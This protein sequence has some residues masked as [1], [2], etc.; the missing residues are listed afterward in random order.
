[1]N[2]P[3]SPH[4]PDQELPKAY[5]PKAVEKEWYQ[6]WMKRGYF[7]ASSHSKKKPYTIVIPPPNITGI[8]HMGHALN[9]T[10]QDILI[11]YKR[12][13]GYEALWMPGTD[14]AG[15]ATQNVVEKSLKEEGLTRHALGR[16]KFLERVWKWRE[17][18]GNTIIRQLQ[19]LGASCDWE[20]TRF[21]MDEGLSR[22]VREVFVRLHEKGLIYRGRYIINW[23]P[24]CQTAL[25]DEEVQ[26]KDVTGHLY[27]LKYTIEGTDQ[28]LTIATT[29]PETMLGDTAVGFHP[30]DERYRHLIGKTVLLPLLNRKL[31]VI[32]DADIDPQFGTGA[33]KI[34]PAHDPVDFR[35]AQ[36]HHL[37]MIN[38][39]NPDGTLNDAAGPYKGL[40]RFEARRKIIAELEDRRILLETKEHVHAVGHCYRCQT[41]VEPTLSLQWFVH[42]K[43]LARP[44]IAAVKEGKTVFTPARWTKVYLDW[45]TNIKDWCIS[46]QIWWGHRIPVWYCPKCRADEAKIISSKNFTP[47]NKIYTET[48]MMVSRDAPKKCAACGHPDLIQDADVLDTWFS[49]WLWPFST[50]GWPEKNKDLSFFY[51]TSTL[52]TGYEIIFFWVA[53]MM[54]AGFEFM[55]KEPF[56][57]VYIHGI[58]RDETGAKMSKSLGNAVDPIHIIDEF[59]AD[60]LR[61]AIISITAEGQDVYASKEKFEVGRNFANKIWNAGRFVLMNLSSKPPA[62]PAKRAAPSPI[63]RWILSRLE[64]TVYSVTDSLDRSRFSEAAAVLYDFFWHQFC[65]WY[66]E[67][68]KPNIQSKETQAVLQKVFDTALRLLHPFMPFITET[69]WQ[70]LPHEGQSI[71][72]SAW[73]VADARRVDKK[74]ESEMDLVIGEIQAIR[75][76]RSAWQINP[77]EQVTVAIKVSREKELQILRDYSGTIAQ[78]AKISS[79]QIGKNI[80][81][82]KESAVANIGRVETYVI[83]SGLV[84]IRVERERIEGAL[85]DVEKMIRALEIRL[86]NEDFLKKAP[87]EIVDKEKEKAAELENRKHRLEENLR[88]LTE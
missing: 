3:P 21:T 14:H 6:T 50:F 63:D 66:L 71:M 28:H 57:Q 11:R 54:M 61:F 70:K 78:M 48:G 88:A 38:I 55:G 4:A 33:L 20:R 68:A 19:R 7:S 76:V 44:A 79:L 67:L 82:P 87:K 73:P 53:R 52:V 29:R 15:I 43:P 56:K 23:C 60:A 13:S 12:M 49:S 69:L 85:E 74:I 45:M 80:K 40:D 22:A 64:Q 9:N 41:V 18:Y 77:K 62:K 25:S 51:P 32:E 30:E 72:Q 75:N 37:E 86:R 59:G 27:Y 39:L 46:R 36:K 47:G 83:L 1:M 17:K 8:L 5:N 31:K 26:H 35:L 65:D 42:M 81:R 58:V 10:L 2:T 34:T 24:R 84:D 16:E